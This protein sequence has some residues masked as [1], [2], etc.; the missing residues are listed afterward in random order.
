MKRR[1]RLL[2]YPLSER[3]PLYGGRGIVRIR[4]DRKISNGDSCNSFDIAFNNH[5]GTHLDAPRHF[6]NAGASLDR[7]SINELIFDRPFIL[8]CPKK[9]DELIGVKDLRGIGKCDI[10]LIRTGFYKYRGSNKYI[11][12]NPGF[13]I[14]AAQYIRDRRPFIKALG[15]DTISIT[16]YQNREEGRGA[17]KVL[18]KPGDRKN[19]GVLLIEDMDLSGNLRSLKRVYSVPVFFRNIDSAPVTVIGEY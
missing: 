19:G 11:F 9:P 7:Y 13:S 6:F 1:Y 15:I 12:R 8:D 14:P 2:S 3:T 10:L 4:S 18:L 16:P 17:H 5:S